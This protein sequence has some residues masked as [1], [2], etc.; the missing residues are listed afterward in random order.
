MEKTMEK[1]IYPA[2]SCREFAEKVASSDPTPGGGGAAAYCGAMGAGLLAM[3]GRCTA[4]KKAYADVEAEVQELIRLAD[5]LREELLAGVDG[6]AAA[7]SPLSKAYGLPAN[8]PEEKAEKQQRLAECSL[9]AAR[10]PLELAEKAGRGLDA[11]ARLAEIG[12]RLV[13]SD[14]VCGAAMLL[15]AQ[16]SLAVTVRINLGALRAAGGD[17]AAFAEQAEERLCSLI[18]EGE[19]LEQ[20]AAAKAAARM[21]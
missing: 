15:A 11:A 20:V 19:R 7:F 16:K 9:A 6:D 8:S 2:L 21:N 3:V 13:I 5:G 1:D 10:L 4:G 18:L 14:A 12:S 17:Y